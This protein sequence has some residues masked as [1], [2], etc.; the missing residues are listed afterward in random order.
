MDEDYW[1][2]FY[3]TWYFVKVLLEIVVYQIKIESNHI[4]KLDSI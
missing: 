4:A 3:P 2:V 1:I